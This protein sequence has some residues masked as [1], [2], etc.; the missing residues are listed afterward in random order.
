MAQNLDPIATAPM[1]PSGTIPNNGPQPG[2]FVPGAA[3]RD[4]SMCSLVLED[5][6]AGVDGKLTFASFPGEIEIAYALAPYRKIGGNRN[7]QPLYATYQGGDWLPFNLELQF[8]AGH[9]AGDVAGLPALGSISPSQMEQL[10]IDME[11]KVNWT[12]AACFPFE[13]DDLDQS[14]VRP[15]N[16]TQSPDPSPTA[17][18]TEIADKQ[19]R[20]DAPIVL[21]TIGSFRTIRGYMT[22]WRGKF[23]GPWHPTTGRPAGAVV[24]MTFNP[25]MATKDYPTWQSIRNQALKGGQTTNTPG[26]NTQTMQ[27]IVDIQSQQSAADAQRQSDNAAAVSMS[28]SPQALALFS[29]V[30]P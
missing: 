20:A 6:P 25:I 26:T 1:V 27:G 10:Y 4:L 11:N 18:A 22:Q 9:E 5:A 16:L 3:Y 24:S 7:A 12:Q 19:P 28:G 17:S 15:V 13:S 21:I 14:Q 23:V 30:R 2:S 29:G 8:R